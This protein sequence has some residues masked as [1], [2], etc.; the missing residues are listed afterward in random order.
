MNKVFRGNLMFCSDQQL[1]NF[2]PTRFCDLISACAVAYYIINRQ[3]PITVYMQ[4]Q[5]MKNPNFNLKEPGTYRKLRT[6]NMHR[7]E[8]EM[9]DR[10]RNP[11][12]LLYNFLLTK[13]DFTLLMQSK[14]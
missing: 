1:K 2:R 8:R 6:E 4:E 14:N 7:F 9:S 11:F 13:R 5:L 3:M 10:V 12:H